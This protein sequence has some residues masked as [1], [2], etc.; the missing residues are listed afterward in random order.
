[1]GYDIDDI[2]DSDDGLPAAR[3]QPA[4]PG[5]E[6]SG[7]TS[8]RSVSSGSG[9]GKSGWVRI[10]VQSES[11]DS[12]SEEE[13]AKPAPATA[14]APAKSNKKTRR[15]GKSKN[16]AKADA[17]AEKPAAT[18]TKS[19][20]Q[21]AKERAELRKKVEAQVAAARV[22]QVAKE[23]QEAQRK[24][25]ELKQKQEAEAQKVQKLK[26]Q[27]QQQKAEAE[28]KTARQRAAEEQVRKQRER[29]DALAK[30]AAKLAFEKTQ[31]ADSDSGSDSDSDDDD[32]DLPPEAEDLTDQS[33]LRNLARHSAAQA[34]QKRQDELQAAK[35]AKKQKFAPKP[36]VDKTSTAIEKENSS[37]SDSEAASS[38]S[39][40][41]EAPTRKRGGITIT[42]VG[43]SAKRPSS[44]ISQTGGTAA[45]KAKK[46]VDEEVERE[47]ADLGDEEQEDE[48]EEME[49]VG[50][51]KA[52]EAAGAAASAKKKA[53]AAAKAEM[54]ATNDDAN[55]AQAEF[56]RRAEKQRQ[57]KEA[58]KKEEERKRNK[59]AFQAGGILKKGFFGGGGAKKKK[60]AQS[61]VIDLSKK[62]SKGAA[63]SSS[64]SSA[65]SSSPGQHERQQPEGP[66][67][68][69]PEV[70]QAMRQTIEK[71]KDSL[72]S[73][74]LMASLMSRPDL[75]KGFS[76]PKIQEA[77]KLMQSN[78]AEAK[79]KFEKDEEVGK[80]FKEFS[81]VMGTHYTVL[82]E[83]EEKKAASSK[84][85]AASS[86]STPTERE[87]TK[88]EKID[89]EV[90]QRLAEGNGIAEVTD[91]EAEALKKQQFEAA[92]RAREEAEG[93]L[94]P[95]STKKTKSPSSTSTLQSG[96]LQNPNK[97]SKK[98]QDQKQKPQSGLSATLAAAQRANQKLPSSEDM[99]AHTKAMGMSEKE[100]NLMSDPRTLEAM[101]DPKVARVIESVRQGAQLD[102]RQIAQTDPDC[103]RKI[104]YLLQ[105]GVLGTARA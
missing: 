17:S 37:E 40:D 1:M 99:K 21:K 25:D 28:K 42:E 44:N 36:R 45:A 46:M 57:K 94:R 69:I 30:A 98:G 95:V 39:S 5:K 18:E 10:A 71:S 73:P 11:E 4:A 70:Q 68:R 76:N 24:V 86:T 7:S 50:V 55:D 38:G 51:K 83:Q 90:E 81:H 29:E 35:K 64:A 9:S 31:G 53:E 85:G 84:P 105:T 91:E 49:T 88:E 59:E 74:E 58:K 23:K 72:N 16:K 79:K 97:I 77:M 26:A 67:L 14:A 22:A 27:Q 78:P 2:D 41:D 52:R 61:E 6:N 66:D 8:S 47:L 93:M 15:G 12:S 92:K 3:R 43:Q 13:A 34:E 75:M 56:L 103:A 19:D 104:H 32:D 20:A 100:Q 33:K 60:P 87:T 54:E 65:S 48:F 96:F 63:G 102:I 101:Q 80:F 89:R 62:H 82:A